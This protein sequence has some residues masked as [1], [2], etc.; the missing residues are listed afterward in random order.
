MLA[1]PVADAEADAEACFFGN[2]GSYGDGPQRPPPI[3]FIGPGQ[4]PIF[5]PNPPGTIFGRNPPSVI[6]NRNA[7]KPGNINFRVKL[8][9]TAQFYITIFQVQ[10]PPTI[11]YHL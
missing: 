6:S 8:Y 4:G 5:N 9:Y 7:V 1:A 11:A 2:Y 3:I 10:Y